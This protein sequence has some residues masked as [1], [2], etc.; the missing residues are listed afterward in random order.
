MYV[1]FKRDCCFIKSGILKMVLNFFFFLFS[2][3]YK[4]IKIFNKFLRDK[5]Y[6]RI[7]VKVCS[8]IKVL[9]KNKKFY[10][11]VMKLI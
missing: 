10:Y 1:V 5:G 4:V 2:I 7:G 8:L 6:I 3:K 9:F 11:D